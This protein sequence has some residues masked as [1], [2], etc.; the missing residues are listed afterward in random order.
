MFSP[1]SQSAKRKMRKIF[2]AIIGFFKWIQ[3]HHEP[4]YEID[5]DPESDRK[6]LRSDWEAVG[7][8]M[9]NAINQF[10]REHGVD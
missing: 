4:E 7:N 3:I 9:R 8:D 6:A 2:K 5:L 1:I 10:K